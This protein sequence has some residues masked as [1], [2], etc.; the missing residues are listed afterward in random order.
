MD[1]YLV[2][3][4]WDWW[5]KAHHYPV[6]DDMHQEIAKEVL[7][8]GPPKGATMAH[9]SPNLVTVHYGKDRVRWER[10]RKLDLSG[11]LPSDY[12]RAALKGAYRL[13]RPKWGRPELEAMRRWGYPPIYAKPGMYEGMAYVDVRSAYFSLYTL[14]WGV[15]Y[16]PMR[17]LSIP[18]R[19][20][21]WPEELRANKLARN[22]LYGLLRSEG[23]WAYRPGKK[24][25]WLP[26][27]MAYPQV[28]LAVVDV[29]HVVAWRAVQDMGAVYVMIDGVI[30]PERNVPMLLDYFS[31]LGLQGRVDAVGPANVEGVAAYSMPQKATRR[32]GNGYPFSNLKGEA[33]GE[34]LEAVA[35][36]FLARRKYILGEG[37]L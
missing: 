31:S 8:Q 18:K 35:R 6:E 32:R 16:W 12:A 7:L 9:V 25:L 19:V 1:A 30:L 24:R 4:E 21:V 26:N 13:W 34:W 10:W 2:A 5:H 20:M 36:Q 33:L 23:L 14:F 28:A 27:R 11:R 37:A 17:W 22:A 15:E 3:P 29:L